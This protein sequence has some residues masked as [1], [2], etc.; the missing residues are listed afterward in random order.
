[1]AEIAEEFAIEG[2]YHR[3]MSSGSFTVHPSP[4]ALTGGT[5]TGGNRRGS[6]IPG[7]PPS[8]PAA[9]SR[10]V[11]EHRE[12]MATGAGDDEK[13]PDE[14]SVSHPV[15]QR[16]EYRAGGIGDTSRDQP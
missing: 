13:M 4:A 14:M 1:V 12:I 5:A 8:Q 7:K 15:V 6:I 16:E 3:G 10:R 11:S 2:R 9:P